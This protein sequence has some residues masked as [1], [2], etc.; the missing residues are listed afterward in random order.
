MN[1]C[2][3]CTGVYR[4]TIGEALGSKEAAREFQRA[5][6]DGEFAVF[7][8]DVVEFAAKVARAPAR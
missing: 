1:E 5:F 6:I 4:T 7:E 3:Y 8:G 2:R